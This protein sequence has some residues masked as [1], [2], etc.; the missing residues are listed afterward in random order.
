MSENR[1]RILEMLAEKKITVEEAERL[2]SLAGAEAEGTELPRG[3]ASPKKS[4]KYLRVVVE[5]GT[6]GDSFGAAERVNIRVPV[7][8][9]RA[10][11][12]LTALIPGH[13]ADEVNRHLKEE[14]L[15]FDLRNIKP[16]DIEELIDSLGDLEVNVDGARGEKVHVFVE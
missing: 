9:I 11:M 12:K 16:A 4:L 8:L 15:D 14:G 7:S 3:E 1:K 6:E 2:L 13:A 10:G 5:P